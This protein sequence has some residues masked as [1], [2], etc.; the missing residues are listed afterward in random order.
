M[1]FKPFKPTT[2]VIVYILFLPTHC[3]S[4]SFVFFSFSSHFTADPHAS[5]TM[6]GKKRTSTRVDIDVAA[7]S[8]VPLA[9][10]DVPP[11]ALEQ[12]APKRRGRII[13]E[14][15]VEPASVPA[16]STRK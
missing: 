15:P 11:Q 4:V 16:R 7:V 8:V 14:V 1:F 2:T 12:P 9:V 13:V 3:N 6:I 10:I 5:K